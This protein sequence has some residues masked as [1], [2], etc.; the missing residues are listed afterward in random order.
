MTIILI[1][2]KAIVNSPIIVIVTL[3]IKILL[4]K[5]ILY[6]II[7]LLLLTKFKFKFIK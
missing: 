4:K 3:T 7:S 1:L 6:P 2:K 5:K